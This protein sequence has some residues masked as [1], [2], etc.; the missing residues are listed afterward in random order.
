MT[1]YTGDMFPARYRN[2][3]FI[4]LHGSW[5]RTPD[6]GHTGAKV[7]VAH[8][9]GGQVTE[10]ETLIEG[11]LGDDNQYWGRPVA[12]EQMPDGS[13]LITDDHGD[14]IYRLSYQAP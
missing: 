3:A 5:N 12:I 2:Q 13:V 11:W 9:D 8:I 7:V 4:A 10:V 6:A 1:F 14:R